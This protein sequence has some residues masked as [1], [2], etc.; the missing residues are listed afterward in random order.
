MKKLKLYTDGGARGNPGPAGYGF[1]VKD[2]SAGQSVQT[3]SE[4]ILKMCGDYLGAATNNQAEYDGLI[5]GLSWVVQNHKDAEL[6]IYMDSLLI[7]NQVKGLFKVKNPSLQIKF[8]EVTKLLN[9]LKNYSIFHIKRLD[10]PIADALANS[11][12]DKLGP[13]SKLG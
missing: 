10:N 12:M 8:Q 1:V 4:I 11:A 5:K 3:G 6:K 7:V 2:V 13:V 9:S